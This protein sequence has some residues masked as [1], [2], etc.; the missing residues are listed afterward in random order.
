[1]T[2]YPDFHKVASNIF[3]APKM[4]SG[5]K[6]V[7]A[8]AT[9]SLV[10][11]SGRGL[12]FGGYITSFLDVAQ[13]GDKPIVIMD[14]VT[15][16]DWSF[17]L[18]EALHMSEESFQPLMLTYYAP[19]DFQF[20]AILKPGLTFLESIELQFENSTGVAKTIYYGLQYLLLE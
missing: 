14:G 11:V 1:M 13:S 16:Q 18:M 12:T 19:S 15:M 4:T 17:A 5:S 8:F 10:A 20:S 2:D 9:V 3:G 6:A 7:G